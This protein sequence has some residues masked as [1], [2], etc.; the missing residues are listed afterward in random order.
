MYSA[1]DE[2]HNE[3]GLMPSQR[4]VISPMTQRFQ[5]PVESYV[6]Y[7][8]GPLV[9][10]RRE[11]WKSVVGNVPSNLNQEMDIFLGSLT[12]TEIRGYSEYLQGKEEI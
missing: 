5:G 7:T 2:Y 3:T 8:T 11:C 10:E 9:K 12:V 4:T 1:L 6:S